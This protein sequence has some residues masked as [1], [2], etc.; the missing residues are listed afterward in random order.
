[1]NNRFQTQREVVRGRERLGGREEI[2]WNASLGERQVSLEPW[3]D[4]TTWS[5]RSR[6]TDG[7]EETREAD[8]SGRE[9]RDRR[10]QSPTSGRG[11]SLVCPSGLHGPG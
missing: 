6:D 5:Q 7:E 3:K 9:S 11:I 4:R 8:Q 1:M 2:S 10:R